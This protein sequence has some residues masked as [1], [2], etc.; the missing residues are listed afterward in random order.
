MVMVR[1]ARFPVG[2]DDRFG[3]KLTNDGRQ[4]KLM[5]ARGLNVRVGNAERAA[6][7]YFEKFCGLGRFARADLRSSART[8]FSH[9]QIEYSGFLAG[10]RQLRQDSAASRL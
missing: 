5:L 10:M 2:K 6:P 3:A 1:M 8:H 4:A 9:G 7:A